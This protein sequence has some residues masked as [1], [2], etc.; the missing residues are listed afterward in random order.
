MTE[1]LAEAQHELAHLDNEIRTRESWI[2]QDTEKAELTPFEH[3]RK[4]YRSQVDEHKRILADLNATRE[5]TIQTVS[6]LDSQLSVIETKLL[7]P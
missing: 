1:R 3:E 6:R 4:R 5:P 2:R 7:A